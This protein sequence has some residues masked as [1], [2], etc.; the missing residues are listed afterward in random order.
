[1][2]AFAVYLAINIFYMVYSIKEDLYKNRAILSFSLPIDPARIILAKLLG[3]GLIYLVN[4]V[5]LLVY[6]RAL[7][8]SLHSYII[9][10]LF[11][12]LIW[13]MIAAGL[14][15]F[16]VQTKRFRAGASQWIYILALFILIL[17]FGYLICKYLSF[18]IVNGSIQKAGP[19]S[20]AFI[21]P[22][23]IGKFDIYRNITPIVYYILV[24]VLIVFVNKLNIRDNLDL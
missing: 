12:G 23:A 13:Y 7:D 4:T 8:F 20:Y 2:G 14:V 11:L 3:I 16:I 10:Y 21:Y 22:F 18:V 19:M 1:M 24:L 15:S 5:F 17:L 6:Y 9:Y